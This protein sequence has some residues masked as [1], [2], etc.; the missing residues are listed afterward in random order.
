MQMSAL[1]QSRHVLSNHLP[2]ISPLN[3][4]VM[5]ARPYKNISYTLP[6]YG[7]KNI[8]P[9]LITP[10]L[11]FSLEKSYAFKMER[12]K[13]QPLCSDT[14][15]MQ[16]LSFEGENKKV[17]SCFAPSGHKGVEHFELRFML[18][19]Y[20][21]E[22]CRE[23]NIRYNET[24]R[25]RSALQCLNSLLCLHRGYSELKRSTSLTLG[26][27]ENIFSSSADGEGFF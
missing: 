11:L 1:L 21:G 3:M 14:S 13:K 24:F 6:V 25:E 15:S 16:R 2:N 7:P 19:A 12:N 8:G 9:V 23:G 10:S 27:R 20:F 22:K 4:F 17:E 26:T 5:A 18:L